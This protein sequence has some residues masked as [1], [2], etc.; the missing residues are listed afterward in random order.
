MFISSKGLYAMQRKIY[1]ANSKPSK[2]FELQ[3]DIFDKASINIEQYLF[4]N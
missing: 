1:K 4:A 3:V 2:K